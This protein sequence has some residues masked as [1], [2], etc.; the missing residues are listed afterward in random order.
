MAGAYPLITC[1]QCSES[2]LK[3]MAFPMN[4]KKPAILG[5]QSAG[6]MLRLLKMVGAHHAT[7]IRLKD[8]IELSQVDKS[9]AHRLLVCLLEEGM[10]ERIGDTKAYRLGVEPLQW[11]F[12][13]AGMD[14]LSERF[15]PVLMRLARMTDDAV[16][17]MMRSGD[18]V[19]C[20][21]RVEGGHTTRAY[22][23]EVGVRR[24]LGASAAGLAMLAKLP[25]AEAG[26]L[27]RRHEA[28]YARQRY[29]LPELKRVVNRARVAGF[30]EISDMRV[31]ADGVGVAFQL[32]DN[33]WAGISIAVAKHRS[34]P[35]RLGQLASWLL[36]EM[37]QVQ[38]AS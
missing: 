16:F 12:S 23:V 14:A 34:S 31:E 4:E 6:K 7:G 21:S 38:M 35:E 27:L 17:L 8:L 26:E 25:E 10:I 28:E 5:T 2:Q 1:G 20:L 32:T 13:T 29:T 24:L 37:E 19:V 30:S 15:R 33:H 18:Y 22:I 3:S 36:H 11:G 9:T